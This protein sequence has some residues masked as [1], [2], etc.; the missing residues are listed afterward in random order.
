MVSVESRN[1]QKLQAFQ[2]EFENLHLDLRVRGTV[3]LWDDP[4]LLAHHTVH[5]RQYEDRVDTV[6]L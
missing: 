4:R 6:D 1:R 5:V 2:R 3:T